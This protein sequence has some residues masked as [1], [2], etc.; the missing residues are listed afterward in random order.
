MCFELLLLR[1]LKA[2][3]WL[4]SSCL[5]TN[6]VCFPVFVLFSLY[7]APWY[8]KGILPYPNKQRINS[9]MLNRLTSS[10]TPPTEPDKIARLPNLVK[11]KVIKLAPSHVRTPLKIYLFDFQRCPIFNCQASM[12]KNNQVPR[13]NEVQPKDLTKSII[14][15][16]IVYS[17]FT[18]INST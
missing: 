4:V 11:A 7:V 5:S 6:N 2:K 17:C 16:I 1:W 3:F 12:Y 9:A 18:A 13:T 15:A 10:H 14:C 8:L